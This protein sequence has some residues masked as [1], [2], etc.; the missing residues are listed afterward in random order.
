MLA[1]QA[2]AQ[3]ISDNLLDFSHLPYV[4]AESFQAPLEWAETAMTIKQL[5]RGVRFERWIENHPGF[6]FINS[7]VFGPNDSW[8]GYDYILPGI[9]IMWVGAFPVGS[10]R[11]FEFGR[12]DFSRA[13]AHVSTNIQAITPV[14]ERESRYYVI[15]GLH[16]EHG[17]GDDPAIV[18]Q[19]LGV[20]LQA[21]A[22]D[23]RMIE[24]QQQIVGEDPGRPFMPTVHDRG[25]TM[26]TRLKARLIAA[27]AGDTRSD[28][29]LATTE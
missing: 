6:H 8:L 7:L 14:T 19:N 15:S 22:E 27:E 1:F 26:Y 9:L 12:P 28:G 13:I 11:A 17:G 29:Q 18:E 3:L 4:H 24:A 25:V 20:T 10:A 5:E 16:R 2:N 21:F 23:K